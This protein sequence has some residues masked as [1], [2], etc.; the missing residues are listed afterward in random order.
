MATFT[1]NFS[2]ANM[3]QTPLKILLPIDI[4]HVQPELY[5]V[6]KEILPLEQ[7]QVTLLY[8]L[9]EMPAYESMLG[10]MADFPTDLPHQID[11][12]AKEVLAEQAELL[13]PLCAEVKT[14]VVIGPP[15][16]MV[17]SVASDHKMDLIAMVP[18]HHSKVAQFL[19]GSTCERIAKNAK[20]SVLIVRSQSPAPLRKVVVGI[21]GSEAAKEAMLTAVKCFN[22]TARDTSVTLVN[23]VS[24]TGIFKYISPPGFVA[25]RSCYVEHLSLARSVCPAPAA[26]AP[27][28][29][30]ASPPSDSSGRPARRS[31]PSAG[32]R[33]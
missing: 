10:T 24:V 14:E 2:Q 33:Q 13:K 12:K 26:G 5:G 21:D 31:A 17:E 9:E 19:I 25:R 8:V 32:R 27:P 22:L 18:G 15:S 28:P 7:A 20:T 11:T 1:V 29:G 23:V 6:L 3:T 30:A 4:A 16:L